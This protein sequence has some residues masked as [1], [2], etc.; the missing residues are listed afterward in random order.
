MLVSSRSQ[1]TNGEFIKL[2][3]PKGLLDIAFNLHC[4]WIIQDGKN[5]VGIR[6]ALASAVLYSKGGAFRKWVAIIQTYFS[7][8]NFRRSIQEEIS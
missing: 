5:T 2:L 3:G 4:E 1:R 7:A 6:H 8:L